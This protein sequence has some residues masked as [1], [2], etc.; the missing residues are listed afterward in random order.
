MS[1]SQWA[2]PMP[3]KVVVP[4]AKATE[5][6]AFNRSASAVA[7]SDDF[8]ANNPQGVTVDALFG[9]QG[10]AG[11]IGNAIK[12]MDVNGD[13]YLNQEEFRSGVSN[14]LKTMQD[15]KNLKGAAR[16]AAPLEVAPKAPPCCP[17][18]GK[19]FRCFDFI[20]GARSGSIFKQIHRL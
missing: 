16:S 10:G 11:D 14:A 2:N 20:S 17:P 7:R 12:R 5:G 9:T 13:G 6:G 3:K 8:W 18:F 1:D 15:N 4:A 19:D